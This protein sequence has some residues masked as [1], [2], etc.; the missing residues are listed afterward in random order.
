MPNGP[1]CRPAVEMEVPEL[2][3]GLWVGASPRADGLGPTGSVLAG[4]LSGLFCSLLRGAP[5]PAPPSFECA[6]LLPLAARLWV[7]RLGLWSSDFGLPVSCS[8]CP[9]YYAL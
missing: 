7:G 8:T 2:T 9:C 3:T 1:R 6:P 4:G 5:A